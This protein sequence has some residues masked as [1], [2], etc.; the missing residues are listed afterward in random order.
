MPAPTIALLILVNLLWALN[1]VV[2]KV[3]VDDLGMPPI[4]YAALRSL[5]TVLVLVQL[6]RPLPKNWPMVAAVGLA[7]GGGSFALFAIASGCG[8]VAFQDVT[9]KTIPKG[10]QVLI[11]AYDEPANRYIVEP[12]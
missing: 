3:A 8:S 1:V 5:L 9:G 11:V 4:F 7:I 2:S 6:L 12:I 10:T